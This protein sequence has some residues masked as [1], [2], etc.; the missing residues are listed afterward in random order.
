MFRNSLSSMLIVVSCLNMMSL[1]EATMRLPPKNPF[2]DKTRHRA[3]RRPI[4]RRLRNCHPLLPE[5]EP[6]APTWITTGP[7]TWS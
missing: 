1:P 5:V 2:Q 3:P 7:L 6:A 4:R